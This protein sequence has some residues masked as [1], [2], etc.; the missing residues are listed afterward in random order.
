MTPSS[1]NTYIIMAMSGNFPEGAGSLRV[2]LLRIP[3]LALKLSSS[4]L[5][6]L[7]RCCSHSAGS[8]PAFPPQFTYTHVFGGGVKIIQTRPQSICGSLASCL[9]TIPLFRTCLI[10]FNFQGTTHKFLYNFVWGINDIFVFSFLPHLDQLKNLSF[11][12]HEAL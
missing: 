1:H 12:T 4:S 3:A 7:P 8:G 11:H 9:F 2:C 5:S 6:Q 10:T